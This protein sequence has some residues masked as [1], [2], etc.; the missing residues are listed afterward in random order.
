[1][2]IRPNASGSRRRFMIRLLAKRMIC[3]TPNPKI[4]Q[5]LPETMRCFKD[6][7]VLGWLVI[8]SGFL[9]GFSGDGD[10]IVVMKAAS[11]FCMDHR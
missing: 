6:P 7:D 8:I 1:M 3:P 10:I 2:A 4:V 11:R 9:T 5:A